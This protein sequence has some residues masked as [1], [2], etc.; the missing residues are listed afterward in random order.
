MNK[1]CKVCG[2]KFSAALKTFRVNTFVLDIIRQADTQKLYVFNKSN[3]FF[4][5]KRSQMMKLGVFSYFDFPF[6]LID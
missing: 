2:S 4:S 5:T 1:K 3:N 6:L